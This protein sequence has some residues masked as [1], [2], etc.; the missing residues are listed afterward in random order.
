MKTQSAS[1]CLQAFTRTELA[2]IIAIASLVAIV[3]PGAF[4]RAKH[5][6]QISVC[7]NNLHQIGVALSAYIGDSTESALTNSETLKLLGSG[8]AYVWWQA[9]SNGLSAPKFLYCPADTGRTA[10]TDFITGFSDANISY[11]FNMDVWDHSMNQPVQGDH[12]LSRPDQILDGDDD[13]AVNGIRV[14]PGILNRPTSGSLAWTKERHD[15]VGNIGT[16]DGSVNA[17]ASGGVNSAILDA[18]N[19]AT[20]TLRLVIP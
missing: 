17:Y 13:L 12:S 11:F 4:V 18:G 14:K 7:A 15:G 16:A 3:L 6:E 19:G 1:G 8:K 10:A 9:L 5:R 2:V 20:N